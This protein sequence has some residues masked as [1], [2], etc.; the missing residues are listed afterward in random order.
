[1]SFHGV[2]APQ[3]SSAACLA[4]NAVDRYGPASRLGLESLELRHLLSAGGIA[5]GEVV[6]Q[7]PPSSTATGN[8]VA[9]Q[10][11]GKIMA[12][13]AVQDGIALARYD[14]DGSLD[15]QFGNGGETVVAFSSL[16]D[17]SAIDFEVR[18]VSIETDGRIL[19]VASEYKTGGGSETNV[20]RLNADGTLDTSF[21]GGVATIQGIAYGL[22]V[23]PDGKIV[24]AGTMIARLNADGT[25]DTTLAGSGEIIAP[26]DTADP[27]SPTFDDWNRVTAV[28]IDSSGRIVVA[29]EI[30]DSNASGTGVQPI[31]ADG[32]PILTPQNGES[33]AVARYGAG[34][35]LDTSFGTGGVE[36]AKFSNGDNTASS[37]AI[38]SDGKILV[39]SGIA[40]PAEQPMPISCWCGSTRTAAWT[41]AS[42]EAAM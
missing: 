42:A 20:V 5:P 36:L 14:A 2:L 18:A 40:L 30:G 24:V 39:G 10:G 37:L 27:Q 4:A 22:A 38:Q 16:N 13:G 8:V 12:A 33:I 6:T 7:F 41:A 28:A 17:G 32:L 19:V 35:T 3:T 34:G 1:M 29:G 26:F 15:S 21:G 9:V 11:D 31:G 23:Q 25:L